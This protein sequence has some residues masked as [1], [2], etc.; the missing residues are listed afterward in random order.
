MEGGCFP[1]LSDAAAG[2][3]CWMRCSAVTTYVQR[4]EA[5]FTQWIYTQHRSTRVLR[6]ATYTHSAAT[7]R[8]V[9]GFRL[10]L[11]QN[12]KRNH[13]PRGDT[14]VD[15]AFFRHQTAGSGFWRWA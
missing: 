8:K 12:G 9:V 3:A 14:V 5:V 6:Y 10:P 13:G 2:M 1:L 15:R 11:F 7:Q 4:S